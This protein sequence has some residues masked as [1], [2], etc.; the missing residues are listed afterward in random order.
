MGDADCASGEILSWKK[1]IS[2]SINVDKYPLPR[3]EDMFAN[4]SNRKK[5]SKLDLRQPY[6]QLECDDK[7]NVNDKH[8]H[9]SIFVQ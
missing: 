2:T 8:S 1:N 3:I 9:R 6:I 4:L 5:D 7:T